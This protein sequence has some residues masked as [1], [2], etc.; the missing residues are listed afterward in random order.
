MQVENG[1]PRLKR[2]RKQNW[3][4]SNW[5]NVQECFTKSKRPKRKEKYLKKYWINS[6]E[7]LYGSE[8]CAETVTSLIML[9]IVWITMQ[10]FFLCE[11]V[12]F[13]TGYYKLKS[14][15]NINIFA[16]CISA[17]KLQNHHLL[18]EAREKEA[19]TR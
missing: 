5:K 8:Q 9:S 7:N 17:G 12:R 18:S 13:S 4:E 10:L 14:Y 6:I 2:A 16:L 3:E 11:R 1:K 15:Q 19:R